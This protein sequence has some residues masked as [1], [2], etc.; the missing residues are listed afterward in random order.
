MPEEIERLDLLARCSGTQSPQQARTGKSGVIDFE[1]I[2]QE[3]LGDD[4]ALR[5]QSQSH[6]PPGTEQQWSGVISHAF[7][8]STPEMIKCCDDEIAF[9]VPESVKQKL[10][11]HE[12]V[13]LAVLL[14]RGVE[15]ADIYGSNL[16]SINELGQLET[17]PKSVMDTIGSVDKWT[18]AF[19]IFASVYLVE[20]PV[21]LKRFLSKCQLFAR[22]QL[23]HY[24]FNVELTTSNFAC[25]RLCM[26][27]HGL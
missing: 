15:L 12:F 24:G 26:S 3:S 22:Q 6:V 5:H 17:K 9:H 4:L 23:D 20:Y 16:L 2:I 1:S 27:S 25:A 13:N 11:R 18:D 21:R 19:L 8:M 10:R 7:E 14:K